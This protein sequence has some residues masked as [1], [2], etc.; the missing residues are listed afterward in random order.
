MRIFAVDVPDFPLSDAATDYRVRHGH[1]QCGIDR[2]WG[3]HCVSR[4]SALDGRV[5]RCLPIESL[6]Y[7]V[8]PR[9]LVDWLAVRGLNGF[10]LALLPIGE[11]ALAKMWL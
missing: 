11:A 2:S 10:F 8:V 1:G 5:S 4:L 3:D 6:L 7:V 9:D